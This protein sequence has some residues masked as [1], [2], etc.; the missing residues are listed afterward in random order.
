MNWDPQLK[1]MYRA[2]GRLFK[3]REIRPLPKNAPALAQF[4]TGEGNFTN[5]QVHRT[6]G[7]G[8]SILKVQT[9]N[10]RCVT[11]PRAEKVDFKDLTLD[12]TSQTYNTVV[13]EKMGDTYEITAVGR[14]GGTEKDV[15][16]LFNPLEYVTGNVIFKNKSK[17]IATIEHLDLNGR[18]IETVPVHGG[19]TVPIL[20]AIQL[21]RVTLEP[22]AKPAP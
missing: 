8:N 11:I 22:A 13:V 1:L 12:L 3:S 19:L 10:F 18:T 6:T 15:H 9:E 17:Q 2:A 14:C 16:N 20:P 5:K 21:Y 7:I 4:Q